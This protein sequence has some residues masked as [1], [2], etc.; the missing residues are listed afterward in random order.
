MGE[1]MQAVR[2]PRGIMAVLVA[3]LAAGCGG[4]GGG[5]SNEFGAGA[6]AAEGLYFG[7]TSGGQLLN[8]L[9]L[10]NGEYYVLY[11]SPNEIDGLV[12]GTASA[13]DG[14]FRSSDGLVFDFWTG[15]RTS[16]T[17]SATYQPRNTLAGT[18]TNA[19]QAGTFTSR[20]TTLYEQLVPLSA[21]AGTYT[22]ITQDSDI[23]RYTL[24]SD[25]SIAGTV[26]DG[27]QTCSFQGSMTPR[28]SG[29][30]IYNLTLRF[31]GGA[32]AAGTRTATG[33]S[34]PMVQDGITTLMS[35]ALLPGR[36]D[37]VAAVAT[38]LTSSGTAPAVPGASPVSAPGTGF[39]GTGTPSSGNPPA[40]VPLNPLPGT[41]S[42]TM[43]CPDGASVQCSGSSVIRVD[44][45][46][47]VTSSGVQ[48]LAR[49]TSDL[50]AGLPSPLSVS[51][52]TLANSTGLAEVRVAKT[53]S[54]VGTA[55]VLLRD[56]GLSWDGVTERPPIIETFNPAQGRALL[57]SNGTLAQS[58]LPSPSDLN[59]YNFMTMG[60]SATQANYAN[61]RYFPRAAPS[62]CGPGITSCPTVETAGLRTVP[63]DWRTGGM[64]ADWAGA[65]R[66]H[67]DGDV[68]AGSGVGGT[69]EGVPFP[70]S[71]G[72]RTLDHWSLRY[73]NLAAWL[74]QDTVLMR[75]WALIGEEHNTN[76]RGVA[77]Y[78]E[79]TTPAAVPSV[80]TGSYSGL[81]YGWYASTTAAD[82]DP[83]IAV[84]TLT[85]DFA[86]RQAVV[87]L[88]NA[89]T[90]SATGAPV[91]ANFTSA[92]SLGATGSNAANYMTGVVNGPL[93]GGVGARLFGPVTSTGSGAIP[94]E[95]GGTFHLSGSAGGVAI[96]G[97]IA[98][99]Q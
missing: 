32:C 26:Y 25:G 73:T 54:G 51:G 38:R 11:G 24:R 13:R 48:V 58:V 2:G 8:G 30:N 75:E 56:L 35:A 84:A 69:G 94:E 28:A 43:A 92:L 80:G 95:A 27:S 62:R 7:A 1:N 18:V 81:A 91:Q 63:G 44:N 86:T 6:N 21:L 16:A 37:A 98:R 39:P 68:H 67:E 93:S 5:G 34:V 47:T 36:S 4:G 82:P 96:G 87:S 76:R 70:G 45:G 60:R 89:Q 50:V 42:M 10:E 61:N 72:Y 57:T 85:V 41:V 46:V 20:Y 83:F 17:V 40:S 53:E 33:H 3:A 74:T 23:V 79:V 65:A 71:K 97:F 29:K 64:L 90:Y 88:Q 22:G 99:V 15:E 12:H 78:G 9:V 77:A 59:F 31:G 19:G 49:S 52:M 14:V 55:A 66:L